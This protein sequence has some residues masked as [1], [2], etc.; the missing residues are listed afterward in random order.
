LE[1]KKPEPDVDDLGSGVGSG[2]F[3]AT[4]FGLDWFFSFSNRAIF[5]LVSHFLCQKNSKKVV[6]TSLPLQ[7]ERF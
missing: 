5:F 2:V 3:F 4:C 1:T 6:M 7:L